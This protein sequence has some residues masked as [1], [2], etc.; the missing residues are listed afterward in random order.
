[1]IH[2][3][4]SIAYQRLNSSKGIKHISHIRLPDSL[5]KY[6]SFDIF[7]NTTTERLLSSKTQNAKHMI[8][9]MDDIHVINDD[10]EYSWLGKIYL[11]NKKHS[12]GDVHLVVTRHAIA[13]TLDIDGSIFTVKPLGKSSNHVLILHDNSS[14][15]NYCETIKSKNRSVVSTILKS[16]VRS[17][18]SIAPCYPAVQKVLVVYTSEAADGR[19]MSSIINT[20][21]QETN[22][23]YRNSNIHGLKLELAHHQQV[24]FNESGNTRKD[25]DS[26]M[27]NQT[28]A[29]LRD[30]TNADM[31]VLL[32][33]TVGFSQLGVAESIPANTIAKAFAVVQ[34][35]NLSAPE[36]TFTHE[37]GHLQGAQHAPDDATIDETP[38]GPWSFGYGHKF[39]YDNFLN[40][41]PKRR[42]TIMAYR[43]GV[44]LNRSSSIKH[45]SNPNVWY[46]GEPTGIS[47]AR[48]NSRVLG[49][50]ALQIA[51][52]NNPNEL[53]A[54][55]ITMLLSSNYYEL[56]AYTCGGS[57]QYNY[58]WSFGSS[59]TNYGSV[60]ST[61]A[62]LNKIFPNG[63]NYIKLVVSSGSDSKTAY[64]TLLVQSSGEPCIPQPGIPC[65]GDP[66][67]K[68]RFEEK[69]S[70]PTKI[71]LNNAYPNPFNPTTNI[72]Y[73]INKTQPI[74]LTIFNLNGKE[75]AT[76]VDAIQ[77][78]GL[79][80]SSF[81]AHNL[82]SGTYLISLVTLNETLSQKVTLL[83]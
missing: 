29:S 74:K 41:T 53:G 1:M 32:V 7:Y 4:Q 54:R 15:A 21:I 18:L 69:E 11:A 59:P 33:N 17:Q 71:I 8:V 16:T 51:E 66:I 57:G 31:V 75:V 24:S 10:H 38:N 78:P 56:S 45:F 64:F 47:D 34:V 83:K 22:E 77:T 42:H 82:P 20:A 28:I 61:A 81:N 30:S 19:N 49:N 68:T 5:F 80:N 6:T 39:S 25:L 79:Y 27:I 65:I 73:S 52:F 12:I 60:E 58:A 63:L 37:I 13:G 76:L 48:D 9:E 46:Q 23:I 70:M 2:Q 50:T 43:F 72:T 62:S 44:G 40:I 14:T 36:Y 3:T 35:D 26:L 67:E 55:V